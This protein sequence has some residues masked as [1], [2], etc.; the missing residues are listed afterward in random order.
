VPNYQ[1]HVVNSDY[2]SFNE[3][4]ASNFDGT[5]KQALGAVLQIG[6]E[7]VCNGT[8]FFGAEV[9]VELDGELRERFVV[10][11]GQSHLR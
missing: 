3:A 1:I 8:A 5:R 11:I 9:Q 2:E 10:S 6:T 4:D 7:E